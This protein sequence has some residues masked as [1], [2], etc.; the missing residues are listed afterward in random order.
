M[1]K[2]SWITGVLLCAMI[3][4]SALGSVCNA[5]WQ[6]AIDETFYNEQ[7]RAAVKAATSAIA[8]AA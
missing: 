7:S 1:K 3:V 8:V 6:I 5:V 2:M 4:L